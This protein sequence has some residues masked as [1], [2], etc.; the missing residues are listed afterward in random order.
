M[1]TISYGFNEVGRRI[2]YFDGVPLIPSDYMVSENNGVGDGSDLRAKYT[3][4]TKTYSMFFIKF[5]D[6]FNHEPGLSM[7]FGD[8][9]MGQN[10]Y[11]LTPFDK[12][13]DYD[14]RGFRLT[15]YVAPLLGS[16]LCLGRI[17]DIQDLAVTY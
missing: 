15:T 2:M 7:G 5:G 14:A 10:L 16:S 1:V 4:G 3:T 12:L 8:P 11:T 6:I 17:F 13:E 9:E